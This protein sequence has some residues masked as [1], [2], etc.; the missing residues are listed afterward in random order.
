M[1]TSDSMTVDCCREVRLE[2]HFFGGTERTYFLEANTNPSKMSLLTE[3]IK[4]ASY[5]AIIVTVSQLLDEKLVSY[6]SIVV[7]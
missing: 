6:F 3:R 2:G 1:T 7:L 4:C 5:E